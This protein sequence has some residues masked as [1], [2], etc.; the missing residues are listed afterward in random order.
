MQTPDAIARVAA[1]CV[2]DLAADGIVYAEVRFAPELLTEGGLTLDEAVEAM[3]RRA[4]RAARKAGPSSIGLI[5]TAMRQA[6]RSVEIAELAVRH[7]DDGRGRLR[8]RRTGGGLPADAPPGRLPPH[9][10]RELPLHHPCRRGLRP[11][12]DLGGAAVVRRRAAGPRR[13]DRGRHHHATPT[14]GWC[15]AGWPPTSA[16]GAC[17]WR[18]ARPRTCTPA[19]SPPSRST[20]STCCGGCASASRSTPTTG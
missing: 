20:R 8:H 3:L 10:P 15:W 18:C 19:R 11:A 4:S 17:R 7:R 2:E 1:E 6:A 16:I 12:V 9:R 14:G 13:A 5:V